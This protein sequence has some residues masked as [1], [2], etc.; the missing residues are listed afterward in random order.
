MQWVGN[1]EKQVTDF[2]VGHLEK[3]QGTYILKTCSWYNVHIYFVRPRIRKKF[4]PISRRRI[5]VTLNTYFFLSSSPTFL[6]FG[7]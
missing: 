7:H 3:I 5:Q 6:T 1:F 4:V 2:S